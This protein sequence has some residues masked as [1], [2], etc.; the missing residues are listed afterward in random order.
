MLSMNGKI[1]LARNCLKCSAI[2]DPSYDN[3]VIKP[4]L[5]KNNYAARDHT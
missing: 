4:S 5:L 2:H 1:M 3:R